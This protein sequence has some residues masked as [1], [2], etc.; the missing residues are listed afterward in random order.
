MRPKRRKDIENVIE[1]DEAYNILNTTIAI[2]TSLKGMGKDTR[3]ADIVL[4]RAQLEF[5]RNE[6]VKAIATSKAAR[7][8]MI[9]ARDA[10][11][12]APEP[13]KVDAQAEPEEEETK[14]EEKTVHEVKKL[15]ENYLESKF[16][17]NTT[18]EEV[19][20]DRGADK[21]TTEAERHLAEAE[22]CF[23][24]AKYNE[25]VK[26]CMQA[27]RSL[28]GKPSEQNAHTTGVTDLSSLKVGSAPVKAP[29]N[30][31]AQHVEEGS[32]TT[33]AVPSCAKCGVPILAGD[34]FCGKCG[35]KVVQDTTCKKCGVKMN[36]EDAFCRK[37]GNPLD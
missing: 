2:S 37:C 35:T 8:L 6:Y 30:E 7:S 15:P 12:A 34:D 1:R 10:V 16:L 31:P 23:E 5:D 4:I 36:P 32:E 9:N 3:E 26:M 20:K 19:E 21:N 18:K 33:M 13:V 27:R 22:R 28:A 14:P 29:E 24:S 25:A 11:L 17:I